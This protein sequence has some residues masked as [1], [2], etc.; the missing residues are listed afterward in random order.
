VAVK[1]TM[2]LEMTVPAAT[3][4]RGRAGASPAQERRNQARHHH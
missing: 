3:R 4:Q 1:M 2:T